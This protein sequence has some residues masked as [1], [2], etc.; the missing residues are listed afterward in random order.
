VKTFDEAVL[1]KA[2]DL[3]KTV[4]Q[5]RHDYGT[6]NILKSPVDPKVAV[7]V[8][9]F[10]KIQRFANLIENDK[11]PANESLQ[12]TA[13]DIM[14]YGMVLATLLDGTF[15]LPLDKNGETAD[16]VFEEIHEFFEAHKEIFSDFAALGKK[17][18]E[19]TRATTTAEK[20]LVMQRLTRLWID[21]PDLRLGQLIQNVLPEDFY[22]MED[23]K[24]IDTLEDFYGTK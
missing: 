4:I 6:G 24:L 8:R 18:F 15:E 19:K 2:L 17:D 11:N 21:N 16:E 1:K 7:L 3:S 13:M 5:K 12:D 20:E 23:K 14:G 9:L 22:N 10:D